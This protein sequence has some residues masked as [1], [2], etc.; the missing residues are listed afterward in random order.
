[1]NVNLKDLH[2]FLMTNSNGEVVTGYSLLTQDEINALKGKGESGVNNRGQ[3]RFKMQSGQEIS[4]SDLIHNYGFCPYSGL[5]VDPRKTTRKNHHSLEYKGEFLLGIQSKALIFSDGSDIPPSLFKNITVKDGYLAIND[6]RVISKE[7]FYF[8]KRNAD[9]L[10]SMHTPNP[11]MNINYLLQNND[12]ELTHTDQSR[13]VDAIVIN[14]NQIQAV[15]SV[16]SLSMFS[17]TREPN[18]VD[19]APSQTNTSK[20]RQRE[21]DS[22]SSNE[23]EGPKKRKT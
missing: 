4:Q 12:E 21:N 13:A 20:I 9:Q 23:S 2:P 15:S 8:L 17:N 5:A 18:S 6:Q 3:K 11:K 10:A 19:A 22:S 16:S 1:M 7:G 14:P